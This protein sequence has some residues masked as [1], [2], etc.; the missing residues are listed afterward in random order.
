MAEEV[1]VNCNYDDVMKF[2]GQ[3]SDTDF[4][5]LMTTTRPQESG[6]E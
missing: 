1:R 3:E 2:T 6:E 4:G 5:G